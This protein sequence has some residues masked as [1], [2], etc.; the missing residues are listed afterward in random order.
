MSPEFNRAQGGHYF[1]DLSIER[2]KD[3][4]LYS[5]FFF[6]ILFKQLNVFLFYFIF[7]PTKAQGTIDLLPCFNGY[8]GGASMYYI[9]ISSPFLVAAK[10]LQFNLISIKNVHLYTE[11][12]ILE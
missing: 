8:A 2:V 3:E 7:L 5:F 1:S 10:V 11:N 6:L 4:S 12:N 9:S